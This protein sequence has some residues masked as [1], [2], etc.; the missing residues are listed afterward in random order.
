MLGESRCEEPQYKDTF[1]VPGEA[2]EIRAGNW[3]LSSLTG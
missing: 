2:T 3:P 1:H